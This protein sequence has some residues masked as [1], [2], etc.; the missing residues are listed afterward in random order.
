MSHWIFH[1]VT[2][3]TGFRIRFHAAGVDSYD[4][5]NWNVDNISIVASENT[6]G[7]NLCVLGYNFYLNNVLSGFTPDTFYQIP[8]AQVVYGQVFTGC[9]NA[10]Y[11]AG[12]STKICKTFTSKFLCPP[13]ELEVIGIENAAY[14]TWHKPQCTAGELKCYVYDDG[15]MENG[16]TF[17]P[18]YNLWLGNKMPAPTTDNGTINSV[19]ILFW[20]NPSATNQALTV[21]I[22][23]LAGTL[24]G[25]T[26]PFTPP[27]PAPTGYYVINLTNPIPFTGPFYC[28]IHYNMQTG[29]SHWVGYDQNGPFVSQNLGYAYDGATFTPWS[30]YAGTNQGVFCIQACGIVAGDNVIITPEGITPDVSANVGTV[31]ANPSLLSHSPEGEAAPTSIADNIE[32][33][34]PLATGLMG[35]DIFRS[36]GGVGGPWVL[37][38]HLVTYPDSLS[39]YDFNL[40]P[41]KWCYRVTAYYD[42]SVFG[43]PGQFDSS[44]PEGPQ[45]VT[46]N[47]GRQ[48]PF[49]EDWTGGSFGYNN[50][51][52]GTAGAGNWTF[53]TGVGNNAPSAD[54]SW[55]PIKTNYSYSLESPVIDASPWTCA[56]LWLDFDYKLVDRNMTSAEKLVVEVYWSNSWHEKATFENAGNIDWTSQHID[57]SGALGK[58]FK[59]RF[60]ATGANS[61]DILHW[62]VDNICAY[63]ICTP[64]S[65]LSATQSGFNTT[66]TWTAPECAGAGAGNLVWFI[67]DDGSME[68]GWGINPGYNSWIGNEF[69]ISS[70]TQGVI[71]MVKYM[72]WTNTSAGND[73]L[74]IDFFDASHTLLGT[75]NPFTP[76]DD[77]WDSIAVNDIPFAGL[78]YGMVHWNMAGAATNWLGYDENGPYSSQDLETYY[79]GSTWSKLTIAAGANPGVCLVRVLA[80]VNGDLKT[81]E[82]VPGQPVTGTGNPSALSSHGAGSFESGDHQTMGI[83]RDNQSDS[84]TLIGY[85]VYRT[86]WRLAQAHSARSMQP[87]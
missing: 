75:T 80:L 28:M 10:V 42:L 51:T 33:D 16:W 62:Y 85:N 27:I 45:C 70:T 8:S 14:L 3:T 86:A 31:V 66:L 46:L 64:P 12:Y 81:I 59:V 5:N 47:F 7:P 34:A 44:L 73:Q 6:T 71:Q 36:Q 53:N 1:A 76:P 84:S 2:H 35:Y 40:D 57:I 19:K 65:E 11:G 69:P 25:T 22:F 9:V 82:I 52:F 37:I 23:S 43:F 83:L 32:T 58:A 24:L 21:D 18:G 79:D 48:L 41:G 61:A 55:Q 30:T 56:S 78:F 17:N 60:T 50:W 87:L 67:F 29:L 72:F 74:T 39:W 20:N 63:G 77:V 54:F 68:N 26:Q 38:K 15:T 13:T 49:C 4:I